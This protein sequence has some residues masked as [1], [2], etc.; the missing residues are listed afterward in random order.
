[1]QLSDL[2][3]SSIQ[4]PNPIR[5]LN[6]RILGYLSWLRKR[7]HTHQRWVVDLA[8]GEIHQ[9]EVDHYAITG[10]LTHI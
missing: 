9:L 2:H 1:M 8:I 3:L 4:T 5:L 10:D 7:R 6:K